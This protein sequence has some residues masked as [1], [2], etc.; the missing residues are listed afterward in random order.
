LPSVRHDKPASASVSSPGVSAAKNP[1]YD[2]AL[3]ALIAES[4]RAA[5][6]LAAAM[7]AADYDAALA[8]LAAE[9]DIAVQLLVAAHIEHPAGS[10][11]VG[12][13]GSGE[14]H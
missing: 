6:A 10:G 14:T 9:H 5:D 7:H 13:T 12:I 3:A 4:E 2:A 1:E 8:A 11:A